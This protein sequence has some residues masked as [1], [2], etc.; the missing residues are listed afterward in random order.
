MNSVR[1]IADHKSSIESISQIELVVVINSFNRVQLLRESITSINKALNLAFP[2]NSAIIV[3]EAGSTDGSQEFLE[4]FIQQNQDR[5]IISIQPNPGIDS[6]FSS[7]CNLAIQIAAERFPQLKWCLL[8]E[9]DNLIENPEALSLAVKLL[10]QQEDLGAVGFTVQGAA[11]CS[12]FPK[13]F[14]FVLGL[15]LSHRIGLERM[16]IFEW[17]SLE[18]YRWGYSE[19]VYSSPLLIKYPIWQATGGMDA[20]NFPFSDSD[21][22]WCWRVYKHHWK[23][24]IL[25]ISGV[26]HDNKMVNSSWSNK[27][28]LN[29]HQARYRLLLKHKGQWISFLKPLLF[30]RHLAE[31][32]ILKLKS[33]SSRQDQKLQ[34]QNSC[35]NRI[36]LMKTVFNNYEVT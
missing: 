12:R 15:Q 19:V 24:A 34:I 22:D 30:L 21:T 1:V 7:G 28:V 9:T 29:F 4:E 10:K 35:E 27:R 8:F 17:F 33:F 3:F 5:D 2:K 32:F 14:A 36:N 23:I 11:F 25:E 6:S 26:I 18:N 16:E 13:P 31:F 20:L